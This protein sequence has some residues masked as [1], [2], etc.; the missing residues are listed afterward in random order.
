MIGA[1]CL[2][3]E[4]KMKC[5]N[6]TVEKARK[7]QEVKHPKKQFNVSLRLELDVLFIGLTWPNNV[8]THHAG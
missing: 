5:A 7:K 8:H 3:R 1:E 2:M 6:C 4:V